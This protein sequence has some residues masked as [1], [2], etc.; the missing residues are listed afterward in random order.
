[1]ASVR[2]AAGRGADTSRRSTSR[3]R[4]IRCCCP[5][6]PAA[7]VITIHDLEFPSQPGPDAAD[8]RRDYPALVHVTRAP[9]R[10]DHRVVAVRRRGGRSTARRPA[11][12]RSRSALPVRR[13]GR[14]ESPPPAA[15]YILFVG[16]LEPRKNVGALLDAYERLL[17]RPPSPDAEAAP[18]LPELVLAG[19]A[20]PAARAVARAARAAP[21]AGRRPPSR[22]RR[23]RRPPRDCTRA[24]DCSCCPSFDEG[25]GL[26]VLEAMTIG[27]PV[28]RPTAARCPRCSATPDRSSTRTTPRSSPRPSQHVLD[29]DGVR[30]GVRGSGPGTR[31]RSS[32]GTRTA[33]RVYDVL[34]GSHRAPTMRIGI[35]ARE[36][37]GPQTGVGRYLSGLLRRVGRRAASREPR[38]TSSCLYAPGAAR[39]GRI[40]ADARGSRRGSCP[41]RRAPGGNRCG[42]RARRRA[43]RLDVFFAPAYTAPLAHARADRRGHPRRVVC[44]APRVVSPARRA[45]AC[46]WLTRRAAASARAVVTISEFS[47]REIVERLGVP[48]RPHPRHPAGHH[49]RARVQ[50]RT[51]RA[52]RVVLFVGSI[53]NRR[54]VPDL[55]RAFARGRARAPGRVA[56]HRRR[57]SQLSARGRDAA[58]DREA[59]RRPDPLASVR[60]RRRSWRTCTRRA[61][62][63]AFLSEYEGLG[64]TPLEA[65][66]AGVPPVLLDTPV[67]R[68]SCGDAA[69]YVPADDVAR[70]RAGARTRCCS[71]SRRGARLLAAAPAVL[72]RYSWPRAARETLPVLEGSRPCADP[73]CDLSIVIVSLQRARRSRALPRSRCTT[74]PPPSPHEIIVVDNASTDGSADAARRWPGVRVIDAGANLGFARGEQRRH[75]R[76]LAAPTLLLLN[77]DTVVPPGAIDRL[78][79][80]RSTAH[81]DVGGRRTAAGRR[82]RAGRSCRSAR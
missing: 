54:H 77:S 30:R 71:T 32:A 8:V 5:R 61:R 50:R 25:F 76:E 58:I 21:A 75:P 56:R 51:A 14:R 26:P 43:D 16:T 79:R 22:L 59:A 73:E 7:Q 6:A 46:G 52:S 40:D 11:R 4:R 33:R 27:V 55:I 41:A 45:C 82:R 42:C 57:Q 15:G 12:A 39:H 3:T 20:T 18:P 9:R 10:P 17:D 23:C 66:A 78:R 34:S 68:E 64:L 69:L 24:R 13:P 1:M 31:A 72:A 29:D 65:L 37:C 44:R 28:S 67:A 53:F 2:L 74:A 38:A 62:A 63:F 49:R 35:D 81:P 70:D 19:K 48:R 47:R 60:V 80:R 36:L